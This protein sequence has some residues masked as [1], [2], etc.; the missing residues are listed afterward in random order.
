MDSHLY[1]SFPSSSFFCT[2]RSEWKRM[3][4]IRPATEKTPPTARRS[5]TSTGHI[6]RARMRCPRTDCTNACEE[7][8][9]R[10]VLFGDLDE[11]GRQVVDEEDARKTIVAGGKVDDFRVLRDGELIRTDRLQPCVVHCD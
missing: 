9:E 10:L 2:E 7:M 5:V 3:E 1:R 4:S 11:H 8:H 6:S